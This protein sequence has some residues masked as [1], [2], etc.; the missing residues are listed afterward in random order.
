[1][2]KNIR[3]VDSWNIVIPIWRYLDLK[4]PKKLWMITIDNQDQSLIMKTYENYWK[5]S[6]NIKLV[7]FQLHPNFIH[8]R[9]F[10]LII[11]HP[12]RV[13]SQWWSRRSQVSMS[14]AV[15]NGKPPMKTFL[16]SERTQSSSPLGT[17]GRKLWDSTSEE[18]VEFN[19]RWLIMVNNG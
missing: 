15:V 7:D 18:L 3:M 8:F 13:T 16:S 9:D 1:M 14:G 2:V 4:L 12:T 17:Q 10:P 5:I 11:N 6:P 19:K